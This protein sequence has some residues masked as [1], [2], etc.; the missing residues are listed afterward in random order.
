M[1]KKAPAASPP[2]SA[3]LAPLV[4]RH[5]RFGWWSLLIYLSLGLVLEVMHGLKLD[6]YLN[7]GNETR[8]LMWTLA[9][10]HG[11]LLGLVHVAFALTVR[12]CTT[13]DG[14]AGAWSKA[15]WPLMLA[16]ILLPGGFF[17]GGVVIYGGDP[18]RGVLLVPV[19]AL[20]LILGVLFVAVSTASGAGPPRG[21]ASA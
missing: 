5:L 4:A 3:S 14:P 13:A 21:G 9:H 1:A 15:S 8:R 17:L 10:S 18:G 7:V 6:W 16:S 2:S 12:S 19:G 20:C 11:S